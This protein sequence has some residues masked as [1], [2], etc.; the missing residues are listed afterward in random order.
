MFLFE[1]YN[2]IISHCLFSVL[3]THKF[4]IVLIVRN[5]YAYLSENAYVDP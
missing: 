5:W 1:R 4:L 2:K 3:N